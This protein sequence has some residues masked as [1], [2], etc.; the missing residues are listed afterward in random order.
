MS[1]D[2]GNNG[3]RMADGVNTTE[4]SGRLGASSKEGDGERD[5][6]GALIPGG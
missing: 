1:H 2:K 6:T 4:I 3:W 5:V